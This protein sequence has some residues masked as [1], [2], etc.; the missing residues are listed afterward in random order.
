MQVTKGVMKE[1]LHIFQLKT[2]L[3]FFSLYFCVKEEQTM[4]VSYQPLLYSGDQIRCAQVQY[5]MLKLAYG[6]LDIL[7]IHIQILKVQSC[8]K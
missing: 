2:V 1:K 6:W 7:I 5:Y 8:F 3:Y 4:L